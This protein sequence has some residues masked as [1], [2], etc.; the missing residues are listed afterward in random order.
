MMIFRIVRACARCNGERL[1]I[2][3]ET[4]MQDKVGGN[5]RVLRSIIAGNDYPFWNEDR[6]CMS[7]QRDGFCGFGGV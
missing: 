7:I 6:R 3:S 1:T 2:Y 5:R 4:E